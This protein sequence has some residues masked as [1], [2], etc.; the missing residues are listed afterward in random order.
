MLICD[1]HNPPKNSYREIDLMNYIIS[2]VD[3]VLSKHPEAALVCGGDA[4]LLEMV[5]LAGISW[6]ISPHGVTRAWITERICSSNRADL[7]GQA[8]SIHML[9]KTDFV[10]SA[11]LNLEPVR[12][13]VLVRDFREHRKQSFY[14]ALATLDWSDVYNAVDT[15]KTCLRKRF[16][17]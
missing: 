6:L 1:L 5:C 8:Y 7:F 14:M 4:N 10:L 13:K 3:F 16:L 12:R 9:I 15:N 2:F 11:G 17:Q